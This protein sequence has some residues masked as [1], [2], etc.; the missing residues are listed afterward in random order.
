MKLTGRQLAMLRC[1]QVGMHLALPL[2]ILLGLPW[3]LAKTKRRRTVFRRLGFQRVGLGRDRPRS[4][5][6]HALSLGETLSCVT[7]VQELRR[8]VR[9][10][11]LVLS[12]STLAARTIAQERLGQVVDRIVYFPFDLAPSVWLAVQGINPAMVVVVETDIWPGFQRVLQRRGIPEVLVNARLSPQS[13]RS[14]L[15]FQGLFAPALN[16]FEQVFP[17]SDGE[18]ERYRQVGLST[19]RMGSAGNLKFDAA[20]LEWSDGARQQLR[21]ELG[22]GE[23]DRV[24]LAGSTHPG[25]ERIVI[26]V[27]QQLQR[28]MPQLRLVLVPR[29]PH[30]GPEVKALCESRGLQSKLWSEGISGLGREILI[31]DLMGKLALLYQIAEV[32]FVGGSLVTKGG[33]NP[34]EPAAAGKPILFGPDMSDFPD[35]AR[36]LLSRHAAFQVMNDRQLTERL[37]QLLAEPELGVRMGQ[38]GQSFVRH[39]RGTTQRVADWICQRIAAP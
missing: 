3:L 26:G 10:R 8:A 27:F 21:A 29:H 1:Y 23:S 24:W 17:Q 4:L 31:V 33:Q 39:H 15:R 25:E 16:A 22:L 11:P 5:W 14:C 20:A 35:I 28:A 6:V 36:E 18:A 37:K 32:A 19:A 2:G 38:A 12:V 9:D 30:R 34:I 13:Y 7:L